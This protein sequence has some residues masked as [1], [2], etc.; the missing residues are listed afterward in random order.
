MKAALFTQYGD[1]DSIEMGT[2]DKPIPEKNEVLVKVF[3]TSVTSGDWRILG[4]N[5]P[6][7]FFGCV[8]RCMFGC[9][10]PSMKT[11]G[12]EFAGVVTEIG[13]NVTEFQVGDE[14]FGTKDVQFGAHAE[15][16]TIAADFA[17]I[18][19]PSNMSMVES[20][21]ITF[22]GVTSLYFLRDVAKLEGGENIAINGASGSLGTF[23]IQ[24]AKLLS[25]NCK[26]TAICS[27]KNERMVMD[28]GADEFIDYTKTDFTKEN[29]QFDVIYDTVGKV[30]FYDA[31]NVLSSGGK[32]LA[33]APTCGDI[34][35]MMLNS[36]NCCGSKSLMSG[37]PEIGN[38][39][40]ADLE[41]LK[42][43][44]E[45]GKLKTIIDTEFA[46]DNIAEAFRLVDSGHKRGN[47]AVV[48]IEENS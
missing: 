21:T 17:I 10:S 24:I 30:G 44:I 40:K 48:V 39:T 8:M 22:G 14:V 42:K 19:K 18:R 23:A 45:D 2:L 16:L 1:A 6:S 4:P 36:C 32:F 35:K 27:G 28:L 33:A 31:C 9:C 15:F 5:V 12:Q 38:G 11:L 37:T 34:G 25:P 13:A 3:A 46:F 7:C 20:A 47:A 41:C 43:W 29:L 26:V